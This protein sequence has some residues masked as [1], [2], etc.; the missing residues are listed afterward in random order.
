M[1][2]TLYVVLPLRPTAQGAGLRYVLTAD[3]LTVQREGVAAIS[4]LPQAE[5]TV[6]VVPPAALSWHVLKI[7]PVASARLRATLDGML[8]DILLDDPALCALAVAAATHADGS[9]TVAAMDR[10]W[11]VEWLAQLEQGGRT[12]ARVVPEYCPARDAGTP[13]LVL[14]GTPYDAQTVLVDHSAVVQGPLSLAPALLARLSALGV[15]HGVW[16]D[17]AL[18]H[19]AHDLLAET[20]R[21]ADPAERLLAAGGNGWELAQFDLAISRRGRMVRKWSGMGRDVWGSP[22]WRVTRWGLAALVLVNLLGLNAWAWRLDAVAQAKREQIKTVFSQTF[23]RVKTIVDAPL[24]MERELAILRRA[25]GRLAARDMEAMLSALGQAMP[26]NQTANAID[27]SA[28][29]LTVSG[30]P[31]A[32]SGGAALN[33]KLANAGYSARLDGERLRLRAATQP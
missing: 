20:P 16:C 4:T 23:P 24:Q 3:G 1:T 13:R 10:A 12:V 15:E 2:S 26:A 32:V 8:E 19:M 28:G 21:A 27:Y 25:G 18:G 29:E 33:A 14:A 6:A 9:R 22:A 7:P 5:L 11:L 31:L 30:L 17:P